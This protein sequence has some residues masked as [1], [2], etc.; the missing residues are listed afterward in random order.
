MEGNYPLTP[1]N[2]INESCMQMMAENITICCQHQKG[3]KAN[4]GQT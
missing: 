2:G 3:V 1:Y 4:Y